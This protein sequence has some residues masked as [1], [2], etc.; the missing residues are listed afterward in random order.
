MFDLIRIKESSK[1]QREM[2]SMFVCKGNTVYESIMYM[3]SLF[4]MSLSSVF[5]KMQNRFESYLE[6]ISKRLQKNDYE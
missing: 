2:F 4:D 5:E 6:I 3:L 1:I